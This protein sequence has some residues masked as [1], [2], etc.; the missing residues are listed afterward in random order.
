MSLT[1]RDQKRNLSSVRRQKPAEPRAST[2]RW[3]RGKPAVKPQGGSKG[4]RANAARQDRGPAPRTARG[5][6]SERVEESGDRW[7]VVWH[8]GFP[9]VAESGPGR[10]CP[11]RSPTESSGSSQT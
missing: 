5:S 8:G 10:G 11:T 4:G 7:S 6:E 3:E 1:W 9:G 2:A